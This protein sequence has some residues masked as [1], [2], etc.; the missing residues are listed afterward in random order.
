VGNQLKVIG[1]LFAADTK[2][3]GWGWQ[4][5]S[6]LTWE[7]PQT[8]FGLLSSD[9]SVSFGNIESVDYYAGATVLKSRYD[10]LFYNLGGLGIT[11]GSYIIGG[12]SIEANANNWLF[13]HEYGH[14]LQS[15]SS[16]PAYVNRYAIPS[17]F[18]KNGED[19][20]DA[21]YNPVEQDANARSIQYFHKRNGSDFVWDFYYNP[22][23]YPGTSWSMDDY[24][25]TEFQSLINTLVIDPSAEDY[26]FPIINGFFN[27][28]SNNSN[29]IDYEH[30]YYGPR[31]G[32]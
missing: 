26:V 24:S 9:L 1:G 27:I 16:G 2:Q 10:N 7:S 13:Q 12:N 14:Y 20:D 11:M 15:R 21:D 19:K 29:Y 6:R 32:F 3:A 30:A 25:S 18:G 5:V 17:L 4:I 28:S 23:G 8:V 22:I 31:T